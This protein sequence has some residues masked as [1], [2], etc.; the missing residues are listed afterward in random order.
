MNTITSIES[1]DTKV[2]E[3]CR[4][5]IR[6]AALT[7]EKEEEKA[8]LETRYAAR[9]A[10]VEKDI[11]EGEAEIFTYCQANRP[12][13]FPD[14]KSRETSTAVFGFELT[15]WRVETAGKKI[16]WKDVVLRLLTLPW[17]KPY[18]RRIE[19]QP[20]KP[21]LLGDREKLTPEQLTAIG[22]RFEQDEQFF[23]RP[24]SEIAE[25]STQPAN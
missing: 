24:K 19:P 14:K 7:A 22:I 12:S 17:A 20:D 4:L 15:P 10:L 23:I 18:L 13:L 6:L 11:A 25:P 8:K 16:K 9:L 1:L 5:K 21:A 2:A 3:I